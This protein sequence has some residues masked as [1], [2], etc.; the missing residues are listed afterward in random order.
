M[1][2]ALSR[3]IAAMFPGALFLDS[4]SGRSHRSGWR[5]EKF[6][7]WMFGEGHCADEYRWEYK[8][9]NLIFIGL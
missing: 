2:G 1:L 3:L 4:I 7:D 8:I 5:L 6:I 9:R